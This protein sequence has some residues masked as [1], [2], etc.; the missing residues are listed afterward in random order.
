MATGPGCF[1]LGGLK[2]L[3]F[4]AFGCQLLGAIPSLGWTEEIKL[5]RAKLLEE[6]A[7]LEQKNQ[8]FTRDL[9]AKSVLDFSSAGGDKT[10]AVQ[11]YLESFRN[12]EFG[13]TQ[14]GDTRFQQWKVDQK[15]KISS[16]EFS[17][18]VQLHVQFLSLVCRQ[19]LGEKESPQAT[20]WV[21]YWEALFKSKDIPENPADIPESKSKGGKKQVAG[22][23]R[24]QGNPGGDEFG[25]PVLESPLVLDRQLQ[26]FLTGVE[27]SQVASSSVDGVF[28]K[29]VRPR[30][31]EAKSRDLLRLWDQRLAAMD[32][33]AEKGSKTLEADN[34]KVLRRPE[35]LWERADDLEKIGDQESAWGRKMEI[36]KSYPYHP[37]T[38][39]WIEELKQAIEAGSPALPVQ[40]Q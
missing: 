26:G 30:L 8:K 12:V 34:F 15:E 38:H 40:E 14:D 19:A 36:L 37:K 29:V 3:F 25:R 32:E 17:T 20:E 28:N 13:R 21:G 1:N 24:R 35:L 16:L 5:D 2:T 4:F 6:L 33:Q 11:L 7:R 31:R 9:L 27:E 23:G 39:E 10:K 22:F 18:A